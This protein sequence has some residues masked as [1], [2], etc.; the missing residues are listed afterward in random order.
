VSAQSA[1]RTVRIAP[2]IL[3]ADFGRLAEAIQAA[4]AGG[5]DLMHLD[6]MDGHFVPQITFGAPVVEAVRR[7]TAMPIEAHMMVADPERQVAALAD[8]G[9]DALIF[10]LEATD[11]PAPLL[12]RTR[13][14]GCTAG[15]AINPDTPATAVEALLEGLDEVIVM[16]VYPGRGGQQM[17]AQHLDK[18]RWLRQRVEAAG[19]DVSI[20]VD[21]GAKAENAADCAAAG[22][23]ILVAGS[24]VYN[25]RETPQQALASLRGTLATVEPRAR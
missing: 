7:A 18:V 14:L 17:L 11:A 2:S 12:E 5:A 21:G 22:A 3:T 25:D 8:A 9:A 1:A 13:T 19:L 20:E 10:H 24:A 23:D 16:T 6:V 15:V 4:D